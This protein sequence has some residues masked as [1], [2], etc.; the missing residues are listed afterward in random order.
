ML[1]LLLEILEPSHIL[2]NNT[3]VPEHVFDEVKD[4]FDKEGAL[5]STLRK[6]QLGIGLACIRDCCDSGGC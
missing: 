6:V 3:Q 1:K 5:K 2:Q 4:E